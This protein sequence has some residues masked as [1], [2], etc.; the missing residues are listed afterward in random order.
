MSE[1]I[2]LDELEAKAKAATPG[3]WTANRCVVETVTVSGAYRTVAECRSDL[4]IEEGVTLSDAAFIAAANP[5]V[6]LELVSQLRD[7]R[8]IVR[9][10]AA[11][12]WPVSAVTTACALCGHNPF[13]HAETCPHRRAV[14]FQ[15]KS[16]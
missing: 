9:D 8:A 13:G 1:P 3:D 7:T 14:E 4:L 5:A 6:V 10:L 15:K 12:H 11:I 2:D 16:T